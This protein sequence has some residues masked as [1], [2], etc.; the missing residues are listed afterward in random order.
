MSKCKHEKRISRCRECGGSELCI[1]DRIKYACKECK[2]SQICEHENI[3]TQCKECKGCSICVHNI[4]KSICKECNGSE[5]CIHKK[6]KSR[7]KEC[8]GNELCIHDRYKAV[9]KIC[10]GGSVCTHNRIRSVCKECNG[11]SICDHDKRRCECAQCNGSQVCI[12]KKQKAKCK[13]CNGSQICEHTNIRAQCIECD[14]ASI[15]IHKIIKS[16]CKDC[17]GSSLCKTPLCE[18]RKSKKYEGYCLR[19]FAHTFPDKPISR[20]YKT[21]E[22]E[23]VEFIKKEFPDYSWKYD[24]II[25]DSC[26]NKRPDIFLDLGYQII[27]IE[28]DENQHNTSNYETSCEHKRIM[29]LSKDVGEERSIIFIRF[30]PDNYVKNNIKITSCWGL[31]EKRVLLIKKKKEW[32]E[33]L[34]TLK[35][36]IIYWC[37]PHNKSSK[38]IEIKYLFFNKD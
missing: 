14:G 32:L 35:N 8:G 11:G 22:R 3:K 29:Q 37:N 38:T 6:R 25:Q 26:S 4:R 7:C 19:C 28:I 36:Q 17:G 31:D 10:K 2:G 20:N 16:K 24:K 1:H 9:C 12:H 18:L 5:I 27:I 30:N 33:R 34:D 21:K 15:C 23:V 13:E